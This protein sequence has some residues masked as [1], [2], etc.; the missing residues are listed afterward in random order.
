MKKIYLSFFFLFVIFIKASF[1]D[2]KIVFINM[3]FVLNNSLS[4]KD[5]Q[6]QIKEKNNLLQEKIN[7]YQ[8]DIDN[9]KKTILTQKNV[10]SETEYKKKVAEIQN[11]IKEINKL[12][13]KEDD[14]LKN[15]QKKIEK[16]FFNNLNPI[17]EN[18]AIDNSIGIILNKKDLL[19]AKNSL[20]I[21]QDITVLLDEK[22]KKLN[23][24]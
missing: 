1:A 24:D 19:M 11:Q 7:K 18:Y 20:D 16:E 15:F 2:Q 12:I 6:L 13:S 10:L 21:T 22:I 4:G 8:L 23:L 9:K 3:N 5:L 17:I 14:N